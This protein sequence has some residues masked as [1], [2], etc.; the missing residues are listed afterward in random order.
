MAP[1][2]QPCRRCQRRLMGCKSRAKL[3]SLLKRFNS[4]PE[5][6]WLLGT[7]CVHFPRS[8]RS[9]EGLLYECWIDSYHETLRLRWIRCG[10]SFAADIKRRRIKCIRGFRH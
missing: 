2:L 5:V 8:Q 9:I 10:P 3:P 1:P 6:I 7:M 4:S